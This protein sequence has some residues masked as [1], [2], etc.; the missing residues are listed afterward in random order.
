MGKQ[1]LALRITGKNSDGEYW[2]HIDGVPQKAGFNLGDPKGMIA[3]ALLMAASGHTYTRLDPNTRVVT[4][5][6]LDQWA[7]L[8]RQLDIQ[9]DYGW[10]IGDNSVYEIRAII[11]EGSDGKADNH[12]PHTGTIEASD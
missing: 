9:D 2:L 1:E 3:S 5:D 8:I 7:A 11:G 10:N 12:S 4:V 6:Q